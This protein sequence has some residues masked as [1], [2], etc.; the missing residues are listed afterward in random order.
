MPEKFHGQ[1]SLAGYSP[2]GYKEPNTTE[3]THTHTQT[4]THTNTHTLIALLKVRL[5]HPIKTEVD[6]F[7]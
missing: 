5:L 2:W 1:R 7:S 4:H 3:H 6:Y